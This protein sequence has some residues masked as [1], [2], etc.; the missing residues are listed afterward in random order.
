MARGTHCPRM[1]AERGRSS[2]VRIYMPH[3]E[4]REE[5]HAGSSTE[6]ICWQRI[7]GE[8]LLG[9]RLVIGS[10]NVTVERC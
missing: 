6:N 5:K 2:S 3:T 4:L 7:T 1:H 8:V 10:R 9:A